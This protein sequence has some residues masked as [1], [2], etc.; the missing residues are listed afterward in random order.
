MIER[1]DTV[2]L[3]VSNVEESR[4]WYQK[5]LGFEE[6]FKGE[7]YCILNIGNSGVPLTIEEGRTSSHQEGTYP[8]FFTKDIEQIYEKLKEQG[9][10]VSE[11]Q[12]DGVNMFFD[13]YDMD[14]NKL[15]VCFWE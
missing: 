13:F 3:K 15:Q 1:I 9:V 7:G 12:K 6:A 14:N 11:I 8:I 10:N 5:T 4:T 2:C